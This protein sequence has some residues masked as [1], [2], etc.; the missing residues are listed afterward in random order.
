MKILIATA[1]FNDKG[2]MVSCNYKPA[3]PDAIL[4]CW[5]N[6]PMNDIQLKSNMMYPAFPEYKKVV[7]LN[8]YAKERLDF[9]RD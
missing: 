2:L 9:N 4:C 1:W 7:K 5:S 6:D 8:V 3:W